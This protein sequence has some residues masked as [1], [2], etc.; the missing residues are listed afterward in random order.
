MMFSIDYPFS[1]MERG[2]D[3]VHSLDL[4]EPELTRFTSGNAASL[5]KL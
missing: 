3:F 5:F 2:R 4:S 1:P